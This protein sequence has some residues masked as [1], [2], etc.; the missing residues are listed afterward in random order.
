MAE[1]MGSGSWNPLFLSVQGELTEGS[2]LAVTAALP[3]R[4]PHSFRVTVVRGETPGRRCVHCCPALFLPQH[5]CVLL[6]GPPACLQHALW[7]AQSSSRAA[8]SLLRAHHL[9]PC[10]AVSPGHELR[11]HGTLPI[12][13]LFTGTH[14]FRIEP[15]AS[16]INAGGGS[17]GGA[18]PGG[19][20]FVQGE[21][22]SGILV[23]LAA[24][25]WQ[26]QRGDSSA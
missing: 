5:S 1:G 12:P 17:S 9:L 13:G 18:S 11:W 24:A 16:S 4:S 26:T 7:A 8:L 19:C 20:R 22:F 15:A 14:Y 10:L 3:G 21:S 23:P 6:A 2:V 25:S